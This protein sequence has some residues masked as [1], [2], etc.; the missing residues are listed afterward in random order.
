MQ[1]ELCHNN[2]FIDNPISYHFL[3]PSKDIIIL[4]DSFDILYYI[5]ECRNLSWDYFSRMI[6]E[7]NQLFF[8]S[9]SLLYHLLKLQIYDLLKRGKIIEAKELFTFNFKSILNKKEFDSIKQHFLYLFQNNLSTI[10][11]IQ[12]HFHQLKNEFFR[13]FEIFLLSSLEKQNEIFIIKSFRNN[14]LRDNILSSILEFNLTNIEIVIKNDI[15]SKIQMDL[16][17]EDDVYSYFSSEVDTHSQSQSEVKCTKFNSLSSIS[18]IMSNLQKN[19]VFKMFN[20]NKVSKENKEIV[21]TEEIMSQFKFPNNSKIDNKNDHNINNNSTTNENQTNDLYNRINDKI[22]I[23]NFREDDPYLNKNHFEK[24][25]EMIKSSNKINIKDKHPFLRLFKPKFMK[26]ENIDKTILRKFRNYMKKIDKET[27]FEVNSMKKNFIEL[28]FF[29]TFTYDGME[30]KSFNS[31]YFIW[32]FSHK[33]IYYE[34]SEFVIDNNNSILENFIDKYDLHNI[35]ADV[36][37]HLKTYIENLNS[38][39]YIEDKEFLINSIK[40]RKAQYDFNHQANLKLRE[41]YNCYSTNYNF[42]KST[43]DGNTYD[44]RTLTNENAYRANTDYSIDRLLSFIGL[45]EVDF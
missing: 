31:N 5:N 16:S 14:T 1:S 24:K 17:N 9:P 30:F 19:S 34:Y 35:E 45:N 10:N 13:F 32:L 36:I 29:P 39:Y 8:I 38:L 42:E 4:K 37:P 25:K 28:N 33:E 11:A 2:Y 15:K 23:E 21:K 43:F 44:S 40:T 18:M 3:K 41:R 26:K 12:I 20:F 22:I 27:P 6:L 7:Y